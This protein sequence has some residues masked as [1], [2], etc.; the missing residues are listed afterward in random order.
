MKFPDNFL[1]GGAIASAQAEGAFDADGR[2]LSVYDLM[3]CG[4]NR[5]QSFLNGEYKEKNLIYPNRQ[6]IDFY[7]RYKE[8]IKLLAEMGFKAFRFSISWS[9]IFP[10]GIEE[11][12]NEAGL[13][14]YE[15]VIDECLKYKIEPVITILHYDIPLYLVEKY[16]GFESRELVDLFE[17]YAI[18]LF[19]RFHDKVHYWMTINE[20]NIMRYSPLDAGIKDSGK[21]ELQT[22]FQ[23]AHHQ[24][25]ASA[26]AVIAH[27]RICKNSKIGMML[28]YEPAYPKTCH[29][30]DILLA[31]KSENELLFFSDVM[32]LGYYPETMKHYFKNHQIEIY[33]EKG[34]EDI[35]KK[36]KVDYIALSYYSS[37][38]CSSD[39]ADQKNVKRGNII[40]GIDNPYLT[41]TDW[42]WTIDS[43]GLQIS[44][45]RLYYRYHKPLF[46]VECGIGM[47]ETKK[48]GMIEDNYRIEYFK[49]HLIQ[50]QE[51]MELGVEVM[52]FLAWSP[53]DMPSAAS[54]E[55]EKRYG[56]IYVDANNQ[57]QGSYDRSPKKSFYWYQKVIQTNGECLTDTIS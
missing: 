22:I 38:V 11:K 17:R 44:L 23:A 2:G 54:G 41:T 50:V 30:D 46:I 40:Y 9:R 27:N 32:V 36:G 14:F 10:K 16:N 1:W 18:T 37:A 57:L 20:I 24:F 7:H 39:P 13:K 53:M 26:K 28:G 43:K 33:M 29:P 49:E 52:G 21:N 31:E 35:L 15:N 34:D 45:L 51:A 12:P 42:G 4:K 3:P 5:V 8:D 56:F 25:L 55:Q 19:E 6:G 48:E 47:H